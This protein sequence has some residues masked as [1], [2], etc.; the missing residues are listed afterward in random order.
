MTLLKYWVKTKNKGVNFGVL[1]YH[2]QDNLNVVSREKMYLEDLRI[3]KNMVLDRRGLIVP[4]IH[5][6]GRAKWLLRFRSF[7]SLR[8]SYLTLRWLYF[9]IRILS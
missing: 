2:I 6:Q 8:L 5:C 9:G 1:D 7:L 3:R 4:F